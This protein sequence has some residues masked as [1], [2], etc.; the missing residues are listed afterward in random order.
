MTLHHRIGLVYLPG[1]LP[2]FEDFGNLPT[3]L[4][5]ADALVDG[6]PAS[7]V[8]DMLIIPGG[9][10]VESQSVNPQVTREI[11]KMA[12][13]SKFVLGVCSGFQVLAKQTDVGRLSTIPITREG[14]GLLDAEFSPLICTDRVKADIVGKCFLTQDIGK[15]VTGFHCHTYGQIELGKEAKPILVTHADHVNYFKGPMD[16]I[17][18]VSNKAG[19]IVGVFIHG[20][21]DHNPTITESIM[22]SVG[23]TQSDLAEIKAANAQLLANIKGEV[24]IATGIRQPAPITQGAPK[25]LMVTALG[26]GSGKTFI[27]TGISGALKKRGYNVG[28]I[29]V[30]GDIRDS[31]PSLYLTKEPMRPYSSIKIGETGWVPLEQAIEA[32]SKDYNFLLVEGAMSAFTGLLNNKYK[33]PMSTVEVAAALGASTILIVACDQK[34]IEGALMDTIHNIAALRSLGVNTTGVILNK[35]YISYMTKEIMAVI[36]QAFAKVGVQLLGMVPRLDLEHRGMIPEVE[37]RYEDFCA[38]AID[39]IEKSLDLELLT[40]IAVPPK[41]TKIDYDALTA[42]FRN[43]LTNYNPDALQGGNPKNC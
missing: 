27:V 14:L 20:L 30:G 31:V 23:I 28:V 37:I 26:S 6:K 42:Q 16:L 1:A 7:E 35:L 43:L 17:S 21:L 39:A 24:G 13:M 3:D 15:Q 9:S 8:L 33:R 41:I 29:K 5:G 2:C 10:L 36:Q 12:E 34:G 18:G 38:Q 40:K 25:L 32:A 22:Q 11:I 4:V 19:N